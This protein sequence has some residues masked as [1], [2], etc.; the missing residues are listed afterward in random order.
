MSPDPVIPQAKTRN[1]TR[2]KQSTDVYDFNAT[3][4][5]IGRAEARHTDH[6]SPRVARHESHSITKTKD[7]LAS[8]KYKGKQKETEPLTRNIPSFESLDGLE[9]EE[10]LSIAIANSKAEVCESTKNGESSRD[11]RPLQKK[12]LPVATKPSKSTSSIKIANTISK[13]VIPKENQHILK[14][15]PIVAQR[16][17]AQAQNDVNNKVVRE[18][19]FEI[20]LEP[21]MRMLTSPPPP[22]PSTTGPS[23][24]SYSPKPPPIQD[25]IYDMFDEPFKPAS[26]NSVL[27]PRRILQ[28]LGRAKLSDSTRRNN[29]RTSHR[30][31]ELSIDKLLESAESNLNE[32]SQQD[33]MTREL[34]VNDSQE[35]VDCDSTTP[36]Q[37]PT[38]QATRATYSKQRSFLADTALTELAELGTNHRPT[39][40]HISPVPSTD[41]DSPNETDVRQISIRNV[42]DLRQGGENKR[43][44][45]EVSYLLEGLESPSS[46][47]STVIEL[48]IKLS[49][50]NFARKFRAADLDERVWSACSDV[51]DPIAMFA[52]MVIVTV[53]LQLGDSA[54]M[55]LTQ[56]TLIQEALAYERDIE[57]YTKDRT[58]KA[59]KINKMSIVALRAEVAKSEAFVAFDPGYRL[60][61]RL[62]AL[63]SANLYCRSETDKYGM[64]SRIMR[65][66]PEYIDTPDNL[67]VELRLVASV[68][69]H[70]PP[71]VQQESSTTDIERLVHIT[72]RLVS[73]IDN[74]DEK[75]DPEASSNGSFAQNS[76]LRCLISIAN[77][78]PSSVPHMAQD[79]LIRALLRRVSK[80]HSSPHPQTTEPDEHRDN[81]DDD[82]D[83][84]RVLH[85]GLL[86]CLAEE[87]S[88]GKTIMLRTREF[89]PSPRPLVTPRQPHRCASG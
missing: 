70:I 85:L 32:Q 43:F 27:R 63:M 4:K 34:V 55:S 59:S 77:S 71:K 82:D 69:E 89:S 39:T 45:D 24:M 25:S 73:A 79:D 19:D 30:H 28:S 83:D 87:S 22:P 49:S 75:H 52:L 33:E 57:A 62:L 5:N 88:A 81:D 31:D 61:P 50:K 6:K 1:G 48:G 36:I 40:R 37:M 42:H 53:L 72:T 2:S 20:D 54:R 9:I 84:A 26:V 23:T 58:V 74:H 68:L 16:R 35:I 56:G 51:R 13:D 41:E 15:V 17:E 14:N 66:L 80:V 76:L 38:S 78:V 44:V 10:D 60:S 67:M 12:I 21:S 8:S 64:I 11:K 46:I 29:D 86:I 3:M 7:P 18:T 47:Q 65:L